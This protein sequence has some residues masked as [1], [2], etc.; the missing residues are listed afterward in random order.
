MGSGSFTLDSIE[1]RVGPDLKKTLML[2]FL[3]AL[4]ILSLTPAM[5]EMVNDGDFSFSS[6]SL[7]S[8]SSVGCVAGAVCDVTERINLAG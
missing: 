8:D 6:C 4:H 7:S 3:Q 2:N 1:R 5:Y